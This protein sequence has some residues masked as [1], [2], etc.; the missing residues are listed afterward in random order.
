MKTISKLITGSGVGIIA[1]AMVIALPVGAI[2]VSRVPTNQ[3][4]TE[5]CARV[6]TLAEASKAKL[7]ERLSAMQLDFQKRLANISSRQDTVD[8]KATT[9]RAE[10]NDKF[11]AKVAELGNK[12]DITEAQLAAI[13][14]FSKDIH[15]AELTRETA[16]DAARATYRQALNQAVTEHQTKLLGAATSF[17][18]A[19]NTAFTTAQSTCSDTGSLATLKTSVKTARESFQTTRKTEVAKATIKQLAETRRS[20]V[21]TANATFR[22]SITTSAETLKSIL[23]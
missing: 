4:T 10:R 22:K 19:V 18:A 21:E 8:Q 7:S 23:K 13:D 11:D 1:F 9:F 2:S 16:V 12:A 3:S 5:R 6:K 17:Q 14:E 20:T 15:A